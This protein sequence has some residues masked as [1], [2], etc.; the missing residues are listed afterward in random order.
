MSI[1]EQT[2]KNQV[3]IITGASRGIGAETAIA[4]GKVGSKVI[5]GARTIPEL[6]AI[7]QRIRDNGGEALTVRADVTQPEQA[8]RIVQSALARYGQIDI[9]VNNAGLGKFGRVSEFDLGDWDAVIASNLTSL[10]FCSKYVLGPMLKRKSGQI[11]NVLSVAAKNVFSGAGAYCAAKAGALALTRVLSDEVREE[12]IRVTAVLPGAT[13][14]SFWD[15]IDQ[16]PDFDQMLKPAHVANAILSVA[17]QPLGMVVEEINVAP[18]L[19]I[20]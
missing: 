6:E 4:F 10:F 7:A 3:V 5:L 8:E 19:G 14:T 2:L 11:I 13:H 20:L 18:P 16:H 1:G 15:K 17:K 9:L 12:N